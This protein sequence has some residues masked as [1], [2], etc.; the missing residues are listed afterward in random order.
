MHLPPQSQGV[1]ADSSKRS[2][3]PN[4]QS[5]FRMLIDRQTLLL[6]LPAI[7]VT[8]SVTSDQQHTRYD[9]LL[10]VWV[11]TAGQIAGLDFGRASADCLLIRL[12]SEFS[13]RG[14]RAWWLGGGHR[15]SGCDRFE[16]G[17]GSTKERFLGQAYGWPGEPQII[18]TTHRF[19][20]QVRNV[21]SAWWYI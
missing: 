8:R 3:P 10:Q 18:Q 12:L 14:F 19:D 15:E 7:P 2:S 17:V 16:S 5:P 4:D 11:R 6:R 9:H 13:K 1:R 20:F 21:C